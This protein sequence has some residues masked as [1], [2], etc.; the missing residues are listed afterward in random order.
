MSYSTARADV[1]RVLLIGQLSWYYGDFTWPMMVV[2]AHPVGRAPA[3]R[4]GRPCT[5]AAPYVLLYGNLIGVEQ[6]GQAVMSVWWLGA[7]GP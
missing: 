7:V 2:V 4:S 3:C 1:A 6:S 5:A